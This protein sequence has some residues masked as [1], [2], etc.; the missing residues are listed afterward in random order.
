VE[1]FIEITGN[2]MEA[3]WEELSLHDGSV[4]HIK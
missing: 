2:T 3:T 1:T 4:L